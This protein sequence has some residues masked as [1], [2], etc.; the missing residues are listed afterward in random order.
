MKDLSSTIGRLVEPLY[1]I[2]PTL[3]RATL[4][5]SIQVEEQTWDAIDRT[6][7]DPYYDIREVTTEQLEENHNRAR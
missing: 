3:H 1:G 4:S 2:E 5:V 6:V 7:S